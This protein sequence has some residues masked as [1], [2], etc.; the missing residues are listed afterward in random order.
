MKR[1]IKK[2]LT[3]ITCLALLSA[4]CV[5]PAFGAYADESLDGGTVLI[6]ID[7]SDPAVEDEFTHGW[8]SGWQIIEE[9]FHTTAKW[10]SAC[11]TR[12][13][14]GFGELDIVVSVDFFIAYSEEY[15]Q[16]EAVLSIGIVNNPDCIADDNYGASGATIRFYKEWE[17]LLASF[18]SGDSAW[19]RD[20]QWKF[21][22]PEPTVHTLEMTFKASKTV[23]VKVDGNVLSHSDGKMMQDVDYTE[24]VDFSTGYFAVKSTNTA[25][26]I[27]N[28]KVVAYEPSGD[29]PD[30]TP[31]PNPAGDIA[32]GPDSNNG[33]GLGAPNGSNVNV[34]DQESG[35][36][37][38]ISGTAGAI[39]TALTGIT[40]IA[41]KKKRK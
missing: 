24:H 1:L 37:S 16:K 19:L 3:L 23:T 40:L 21:V 36:G 31:R 20:S 4:L 2:F 13:I 8:T 39:F 9:K 7:F 22:S 6:D 17:S 11:L 34:R 25:N 35:C 30:P 41:L 5:S 28:I 27:D 14:D 38:S 12:P 33:N 15:A 18:T 32:N 29:V 26:Y 10:E